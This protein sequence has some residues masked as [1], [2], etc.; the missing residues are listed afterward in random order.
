MN[1]M[2]KQFYNDEILKNSNDFV[3]IITIDEEMQTLDYNAVLIFKQYSKNPTEN[4][5]QHY[6]LSLK[7]EVGYKN[8]IFILLF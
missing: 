8:N 3:S 5:K 1:N 4:Y 7:I 6:L 2:H